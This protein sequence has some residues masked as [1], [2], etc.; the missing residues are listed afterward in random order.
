MDATILSAVSEAPVIK[1]KLAASADGTSFSID[2]GATLQVTLNVENSEQLKNNSSNLYWQITSG[3]SDFTIAN[4]VLLISPTTTSI[5]FPI[6]AKRNGILDDERNFT[7][8]FSGDDFENTSLFQIQ[9]IVK[10]KTTPAAL[11]A[12]DF[13]FGALLKNDQKD[14]TITVTNTGEATADTIAWSNLSA[15]FSFKD[16]SFPGT[17]GDCATTLAGG[18]S[19]TLAVTYAPTDAASHNQSLQASF[20]TP[21][22]DNTHTL[23]LWGLSVEVEA[24]LGGV[25]ST[26]SNISPLDV[27]V[28]GVDIQAYKYKLSTNTLD[29]SVATGYS[30]E[31]AVG[32]KITDDLSAFTNQDLRLCVVGKESHN[33][34]QPYANAT[35]ANWHFDN[36]ALT[37][38]LAQGLLQADPANSLPVEFTVQF[39]KEVLPSSFLTTDIQQLGTATGITWNLSTTDNVTWSMKATAITGDGTVVP[40]ISADLISDISGN[41]NQTAL[42]LDNSVAYDS[43]KPTVTINQKSGQA[44][45]TNALP[46]E[47]TITFS[48][49][50]SPTSF[51]M[52]DITQSGTATGITWNLTTS[53]N[54]VWSLKATAA[55]NGTL[56][57]SIAAGVVNDAAG[58][59][60]TIATSTDNSVEYNT[61]APDNSSNLIW[62]QTSPAN[63]TALTATWTKSPSAQ[64]DIQKIQFYSDAICSTPTGGLITLN[65]NDVTQVLT[66]THGGTYSYIITS[67][68]TASNSVA[69]SCSDSVT[70]DTVQPTVTTV[71]SSTLNGSY[72]SGDVISI[73]VTMSEVVNVSGSPALS[74]NT[75]PTSRNAVF[76]SGSGS[77]VLT[78]LYTVQATDTSADLESSSTSAL[79]LG[80][81]TISDIAGNAATLTLPGLGSGNSLGGSKNIVIDTTAPG[82]SGFTI[83]NSSP[84]NNSTYSLTSTVSGSA[85]DYCILENITTVASCTWTAGSSLPTSFVV[86]TTNNSKTLYAWVRDLAGNVSSM[87][88]SNAVTFDNIAPTATATGSPTGTSAKYVLNIDVGGTDVVTYKYKL[89]LTASTDCSNSVNYSGEISASVNITDNISSTADGGMTLCVVGK[90]TAGNWQTY[91][92]AT[93]KTWTKDSP[94]IQFTST[95]STI[96]EYDSPTHKVYVSIAAASDVAVSAS[97]TVTDVGTYPATSGTD[98]T[99]ASGTATIAAGATSVAINIPIIDDIRDEYDETFRI[100]LN[101]STGAY[102]GASTQH[103]VTITDDDDPPLVTIQDIY[104]MEGA[105]TSFRAS[106][107]TPTDKGSVTINWA[108]DSCTGSDCAVVNTN[109]TI[110]A[111]SG[112]VAIPSG[113]TYKDFGSITTI[114]NAVDELYRRVPIK[115]TSV[116]DATILSSSATVYINDNDTTASSQVTKVSV[117]TTH[118]CVL[119]SQKKIYCLGRSNYYQ[120]GLGIKYA[121]TTPTKVSV[122][123]DSDIEVLTAGYEQTCAI[124]SAGALYCWGQGGHAT[125]GGGSLGNGSSANATTPAIVT[126]MTS[127][128]TGVEIGYSNMC[129]IKNGGVW[130][131]G[132]DQNRL[133]GRE[134]GEIR[135]NNALVPEALPAPLD[136]GVEKIS[137]RWT[138]A[139]AL[140]AGNAYCWGSNNQGQFGTGPQNDGSVTAVQITGYGTIAD[141][142]AGAHGTC[143]KNNL[144]DVYCM[145]NNNDYQLSAT[146]SDYIGTPVEMTDFKNA[147]QMSYAST[148]CG[149]VNGAIKCHGRNEYGSLGINVAGSKLSPITQTMIGGEADVDHM[150]SDQNGDTVCFLRNA[151]VYCTGYGGM[152]NL[153]DGYDPNIIVPTLGVAFSGPAG[154]TDIGVGSIHICGLFNGGVKCWGDNTYYRA[155]N[156]VT[157]IIYQTPTDVKN[158]NSDVTAVVGGNNGTCALTTT[159]ALKC[160]GQGY[161][162]GVGSI[163]SSGNP[164]SP[165]GMTSDVTQVA[166]YP[167]GSIMCAVKAGEGYCWGL[168]DFG[169]VG[170]GN[171]NPQLTPYKITSLGTGVVKAAVGSGQNCF[172]KNDGSVWCVGLNS[173]GQ[174]GLGD[175]TERL[176]HTQIPGLTAVDI[177]ATGSGACALLANKTVKCWGTYNGT[178][179]SAKSSPTTIATMSDVTAIY[180][181]HFTY[182]AM[183]GGVFKCWGDN[184][185]GQM[186][187]NTLATVNYATPTTSP[188]FNSLGTI[189]AVRTGATKVFVKVGNNWYG[190]GSDD[191]AQFTR[192]L[193]PFRL[194]P[195]S[196]MPF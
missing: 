93:T 74:L 161:F 61:S 82:I 193:K 8:K 78:F 31:I 156:L 128:V 102:L 42:T 134:P 27:T 123:S 157:D 187:M 1:M 21:V 64:L 141:V 48:E 126:G 57:P 131:W 109:Y 127:G 90:D 15:P 189:T 125:L 20:K 110:G 196:M 147:S 181:G 132:T 163:T 14:G 19:C 188:A 66:G 129:A 166:A 95:T 23:Q 142:W 36:T 11:A 83:T 155:G 5:S 41:L 75:T 49:A 94:D 184:T 33:L 121:L 130:C 50:I 120:T 122:N 99:L 97:Y 47:F 16:G 53:N 140:K 172:L 91:G 115:I 116:T 104:V 68:D 143:F 124:T 182:C 26:F 9:V 185:Y 37:L 159:N 79:S 135:A 111:T 178:A 30:S 25:P 119:T 100:T 167:N 86:N 153:G 81:G 105:S 158:L 118:T 87:S 150:V 2:E 12:S 148:L 29:C 51:D 3:S 22:D 65:N 176:T 183:D 191:Y 88:T 80:A 103:T 92:L 54:R 34:W 106:L 171:K 177:V 45:P 145:G 152:G 84:T 192:P 10:D 24:V 112:T 28:G 18:E 107:S 101:S 138:H 154:A 44:D 73:Q 96:S 58:N 85:T 133:L 35:I 69:S 46:I 40:Q 39:N 17:G 7:L 70:V 160:W 60:N 62:A 179:I 149:I 77:T 170:N 169:Q 89:G 186:G 72:K 52:S 56:I 63:T 136:A 144:G 32:T 98:Y 137:M 139:C 174:L 168:N 4:G 43:V 113:D 6:E 165:T 114:D 195:V 164:I 173:S 67:I 117:G 194:A 175:T 162:R 108:L 180:G 190:A 55:T 151:Q 76:S 38:T 59:T 146:A 13:N 71:T